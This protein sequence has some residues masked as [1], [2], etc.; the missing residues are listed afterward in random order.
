MRKVTIYLEE[1]SVRSLQR[2][3]AERKC[4]QAEI[5]REA[6]SDYLRQYRRPQ[7]R[8]VGMYSSGRSDISRRSN[9]D[10]L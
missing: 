5:M 4:T 1:A 9:R 10:I 7:A 8:G 2:L 6:V 3:A